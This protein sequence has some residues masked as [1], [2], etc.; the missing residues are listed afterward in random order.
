[1]HLRAVYAVALYTGAR[2]SE[3]KAMQWQDIDLDADA[4]S[5]RLCRGTHGPT[6]NTRVRRFQL[7]DIEG[8][9]P[10]AN[11]IT[12]LR[13]WRAN[14][15]GSTRSDALVFPGRGGAMRHAKNDFG[16]SDKKTHRGLQLGSKSKALGTE[17]RCTFHALRHTTAS[18]LISGM[19]GRSWSKPELQAWMGWS[20]PSMVERYAHLAGS[21][22]A[23]AVAETRGLAQI[24]PNMTKPPK[25]ADANNVNGFEGFPGWAIADLNCGLPPCEGGTLPLS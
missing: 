10:F 7:L 5:W 22:L 3:I 4:P 19:W 25:A 18:A 12:A 20:S 17:R 14:T 23:Q 24:W 13:W 1:M 15:K 11:A 8:E 2:Q 9:G 6:K 16:W 21:R